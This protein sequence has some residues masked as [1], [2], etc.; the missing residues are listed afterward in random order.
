MQASNDYKQF[1]IWPESEKL[2]FIIKIHNYS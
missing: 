1:K 2:M